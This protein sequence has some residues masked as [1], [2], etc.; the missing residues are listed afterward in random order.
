MSCAIDLH[1]MYCIQD[2]QMHMHY[3]YQKPCVGE[4]GHLVALL[5]PSTVQNEI[6]CN[7]V[8]LKTFKTGHDQ[9]R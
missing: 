4:Y 7:V 6:S 1:Y 5:S 9:L 3:V 2:S 8:A